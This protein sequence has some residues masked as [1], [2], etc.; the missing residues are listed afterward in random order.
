VVLWA[1]TGRIRFAVAPSG[2][3]FS[4]S[5]ALAAVASHTAATPRMAALRGG[6]VAVIFRDRGALRYARRAPG[7]TFGPVRSLGHDGVAPEIRATPGGGALLAWARGPLTRRALEVAT[8][9]RGAALPGRGT[10]VAGRI[11]AFTLATG[12]DGTA[13]VA[14]TRRDTA[15]TGFARRIRAANAGA[16]GPV[17]ELGNVAYGVPRV[18]LTGNRVLAVWNAQGPSAEANVGLASAAGTGTALG[19][20]RPFAAGGFAQTSPAAAF[21]GGEELVVFTRQ[22]PDG[23]AMALRNEVTVAGAATGEGVVLGAASTIAT[24]AVAGALIAW[25][26]A[27]SGVAVVLAR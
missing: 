3:S 20:A 9:R 25:P 24:P 11:R 22:V 18:A 17:R 14:W 1:S 12:D 7:G 15:T 10:S 2:R 23:A 4:G 13:W 27:A 26:A 21:R 6:T 5:H 16:V 19:P 8:A